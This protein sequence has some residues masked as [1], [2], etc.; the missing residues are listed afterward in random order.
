MSGG[1]QQRVALARALV[2][3]PKVILADEPTGELDTTTA[4]HVFGLLHAI[5][6]GG[7]TV[8][9]ATHDPLA[10]DIVDSAYFVKDGTLHLPDPD[11]LELWLTEGEGG[12][13]AG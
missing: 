9:V 2:H 10:L 5:A 6:E 11:E 1:E 8:V 4:A 12:L 7:G 3:A 13:A